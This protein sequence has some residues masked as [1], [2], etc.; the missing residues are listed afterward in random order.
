LLALDGEFA[1]YFINSPVFN[2]LRRQSKR[3]FFNCANI[4]DIFFRG[5]LFG[6]RFHPV[7]T[8][9]FT[10]FFLDGQ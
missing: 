8:Q 6:W 4:Y 3:F 9:P 2:D 5:P 1:K 10:C 7:Q